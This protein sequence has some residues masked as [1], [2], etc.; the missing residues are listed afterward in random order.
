[1]ISEAKRLWVS[2]VVVLDEWSVVGERP[3]PKRRTS[4][5]LGI[6]VVV[7]VAAP[8]VVTVIVV[9]VEVVVVASAGIVSVVVSLLHTAIVWGRI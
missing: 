8:V 4:H 7:G 1:M 5:Q 2:P 6:V 9:V 3:Y